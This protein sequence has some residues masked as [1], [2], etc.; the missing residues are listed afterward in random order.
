MTMPALEERIK[1]SALVRR[2][3]EF[4]RD[5]HAGRLRKDGATPEIEHPEGVAE[6]VARR[7][8]DDE[9]VAAALLHDV[10][11]DTAATVEGL[12]NLFP[13]R[14]VRLVEAL[15]EPSI[16]GPREETWEARKRGKLDRLR[17]SEPEALAVC[18]ADRLHNVTSLLVQAE[19][20]GKAAWARFSRGPDGTLQFEREIAALLAARFPHPLTDA[21]RAA[22]EKLEALVA[23][24]S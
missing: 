4:A 21:H 24:F 10:L 18:A 17:T 15:T 3:W 2:A 6:I 16:P 11:E 13:E 8:F 23:T 14:V 20:K 19:A 7:G 5:A 22:L 1:A 9:I 12:R